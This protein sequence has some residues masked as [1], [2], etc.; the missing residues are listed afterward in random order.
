MHLVE[1]EAHASLQRGD[2]PKQTRPQVPSEEVLMLSVSCLDSRFKP[3]SRTCL[4]IPSD[5]R[6]GIQIHFVLT[7]LLWRSCLCSDRVSHHDEM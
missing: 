4:E 7:I 6:L 5:L 3:V 1:S 2:S